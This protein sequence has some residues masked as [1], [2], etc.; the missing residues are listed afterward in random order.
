M[1]PWPSRTKGQKS[2]RW[3]SASGEEDGVDA[4]AD[5]DSWE[6]TAGVDGH[7]IVGENETKDEETA[8]EVG[9]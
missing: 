3:K 9:P 5:T 4:E 2:R 6:K 7:A 8:D 1:E